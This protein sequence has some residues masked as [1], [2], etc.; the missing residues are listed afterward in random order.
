MVTAFRNLSSLIQTSL[1]TLILYKLI[2]LRD[3]CSGRLYI[4]GDVYF[5]RLGNSQESNF[6]EI[7]ENLYAFTTLKYTQ[8]LFML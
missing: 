5:K 1:I 4:L 3:L 8:D 6:I 7:K 2:G